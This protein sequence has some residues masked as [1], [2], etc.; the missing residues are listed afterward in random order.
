MLFDDAVD[1]GLCVVILV[2]WTF[3]EHVAL[4]GVRNR[5]LRHLDLGSTFMLQRPDHFSAFSDDEAD[6]FI[7]HG[8]DVS[9]RT[10]R[11]VGRQ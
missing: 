6:A 8:Q 11:T 5:G 4:V 2:E 1:E 3:D 9:L 7:G 10:R